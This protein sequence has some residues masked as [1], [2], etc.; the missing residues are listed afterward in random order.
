[1]NRTAAVRLARAEAAQDAQDAQDAKKHRELRRLIGVP[2]TATEAEKNAA[3]LEY[4]DDAV[5][6]YERKYGEL[7]PLHSDDVD[8][9]NLHLLTNAQFG[10]ACKG[11]AA[12]ERR[13][14]EGAET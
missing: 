8:W 6:E 4:L 11:M 5:A 7:V 9:N 12:R 1:M 3:F 14:Q 13:I 10:A 2:E